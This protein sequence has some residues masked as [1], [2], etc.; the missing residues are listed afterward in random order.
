MRINSSSVREQAPVQKPKP[1]PPK[2]AAKAD[3]PPPEV[4]SPPP[5]K[6]RVDIRA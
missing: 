4:K 5:P 2:Q 1:Q 3:R 6:Q